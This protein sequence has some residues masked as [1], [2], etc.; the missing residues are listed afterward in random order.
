MN[1]VLKRALLIFIAVPLAVPLYATELTINGTYLGSVN[2]IKPHNSR[3]KNQFDY[4]ANVD[5]N[6]AINPK[7][8]GVIQFQMSPGGGSLGFPG[9]QIVVTDLNL[10]YFADRVPFEITMGSFDTPFGQQ[11]ARLSNN[12]DTFNNMLILN[13]LLYSAFAGPM[14]TLNT[15]GIMTTYRALYG[16]ATLAITNG[17]DESAHNP[18]GRFGV[19]GRLISIPLLNNSMIIG[20]SYMQSDDHQGDETDSSGFNADFSAV[21]VDF[22]LKLI[23][24]FHLNAYIARLVYGDQQSATVDEVWS[25]M[26]ETAYQWQK[27]RL[28]ARISGWQPRGTGTNDINYSSEDSSLTGNVPNPGF[29]NTGT[30]K[31]DQDIYRYELGVAYS[32]TPAITIRSEIF[33]DDY[34]DDSIRNTDVLGALALVNVRF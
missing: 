6:V 29:A 20:A 4:A 2:G 26:T 28:S 31:L 13:P 32:F 34:R 3:L 19:V 21:M 11:V 30:V 27:F 10:S 7:V 16:Q 18:D 15:L 17:T 24:Q 23:D 14:G 9:D 1:I 8:A 5:I 25:W 33:W 22:S 12:A